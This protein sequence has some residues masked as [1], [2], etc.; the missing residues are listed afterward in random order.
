MCV[1]FICQGAPRLISS[2][3][4]RVSSIA[5]PPGDVPG[6]RGP[7]DGGGDDPELDAVFERLGLTAAERE[8]V[9]SML[10]LQQDNRLPPSAYFGHR[11]V[12]SK[13]LGSDSGGSRGRQ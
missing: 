8:L 3:A 6:G 5:A 13:G 10:P 4:C 1:R 12:V 7:S 9:S 2:G 11:P